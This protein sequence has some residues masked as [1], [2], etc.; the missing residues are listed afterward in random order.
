MLRQLL[1]PWA[2]CCLFST[3]ASAAQDAPP[4]DSGA[5][6]A[7]R[8]AAASP[9]AAA[10][11]DEAG[12][13]APA[14][15]P[16]PRRVAQVDDGEVPRPAA[17]L[18]A[19]AA[20]L[21]RGFVLSAGFGL[22]GLASTQVTAASLRGGLSIGY[23]IGRAMIDLG[24]ELSNVTEGRSATSGAGGSSNGASTSISAF[25]LIPG[26]QVALLR[27]QDLR[28]ELIGS[29][30]LGFGRRV[31][32][33]TRDPPSMTPPTPPSPISVVPLSFIYELAPGVRYWPHRHLAL[34][35]LAGARGDYSFEFTSNSQNG[36][37]SQ[38]HVGLNGVFASLSARAVF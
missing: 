32:F 19:E 30:R 10:A 8:D 25:L 38:R 3:V 37:R 27:S 28:V 4:P 12:G 20:Q 14:S 34:E 21:R 24:L 2:L 29:F 1:L 15:A 9:A 13:A 26:V 7:P 6:G 23:K 22:N 33:E 18:D 5:A 31:S 16:A 11:R 17:A 35:V 36:D